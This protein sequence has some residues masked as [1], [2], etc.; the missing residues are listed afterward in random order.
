MDEKANHFYA[1]NVNVATSVYDVT[2]RFT[3]KTP[4]G[5]GDQLE[6][7]DMA[8]LNVTMSPQHAKALAAILIKHIRD[9]ERETQIV[10][11]L[12][13]SVG[14]MWNNLWGNDGSD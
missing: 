2:L 1:N 8:Q 5:E 13:P 4:V 7:K 12:P 14:E 9:Y 10:L 6:Q 3:T 11:P